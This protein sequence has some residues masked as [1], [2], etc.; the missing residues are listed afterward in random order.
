MLSGLVDGRVEMTCRHWV[1]F[2]RELWHVYREMVSSWGRH[3]GWKA[4]CGL[5]K[6]GRYRRYA[7]KGI[8]ELTPRMHVCEE[9][10][11][12]GLLNEL[13]D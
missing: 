12:Q 3:I 7:F 11:K 4:S 1:K 5:E 2:D 8:G 10:L 13:G 9:C 6:R